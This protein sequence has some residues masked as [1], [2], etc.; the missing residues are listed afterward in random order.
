MFTYDQLRRIGKT[1]S[2]RFHGNGF[3]QVYL[4]PTKRLDIWHPD[5][6][7]LPTAGGIHDHRFS[8]VS[9]VLLGELYHD[10]YDVKLVDARELELFRVDCGIP[11]QEPFVFSMAPPVLLSGCSAEL[12][13]RFTFP[14]GASYAFERG[15]Y[16][17]TRVPAGRITATL[18]T[19]AE[20]DR[21]HHSKVVR[22]RADGPLGHAFSHDV[23]LMQVWRAVEDACDELAKEP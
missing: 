20:E 16:H 9:D 6:P 8:F 22:A 5:L 11:A 23:S 4:S 19:K 7:A 14:K 21:G 13:R 1:R 15:Q 10:V 3:V 17:E 2:P 18:I 12:L